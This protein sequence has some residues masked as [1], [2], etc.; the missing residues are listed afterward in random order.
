MDHT[1]R[2]SA[3]THGTGLGGRLDVETGHL[4]VAVTVYDNAQVVHDLVANLD[5]RAAAAERRIG[6]SFLCL[7]DPADNV[8]RGIVLCGAAHPAAKQKRQLW[9]PAPATKF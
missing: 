4:D 8:V 6:A 2:R 1:R 7:V 5:T 3:V 9:T